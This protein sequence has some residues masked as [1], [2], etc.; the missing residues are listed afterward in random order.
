MTFPLTH[1]LLTI[2]WIT[3]SQPDETGQT[4]I[5][6][7][8]TEPITQAMVDAAKPVVQTFWNSLNGRISN[9]YKLAFL[10][11]A[12][13]GTDGKYVPGSF[14]RDAVYAVP[15]PGGGAATPVYPIQTAC[16]STL[17]T[18][19]PRGQAAKGRMFL[20]PI[21]DILNDDY[22]WS[23]TVGASRSSALA[24]M[25]HDLAGPLGG[26]PGVYSKGTKGSA[27]GLVRPVTG[28]QT[29]I[30][31]DVQRRRGRAVPESYSATAAVTLP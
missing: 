20:P 26:V 3:P 7:A 15:S 10:R 21:T 1:K 14:A 11:L 27:T 13:I 5:R 17:L 23:A 29:G 12:S 6:F 2:H 16:V 24:T 22:R 25:L 30:R 9:S 19:A 8:G 18:A 28:V 4:G 31:P